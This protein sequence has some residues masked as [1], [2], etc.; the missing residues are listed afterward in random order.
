MKNRM[1]R[2]SRKKW[3][4]HKVIT[5]STKRRHANVRD[6]ITNYNF[7]SRDIVRNR[8]FGERKIAEIRDHEGTLS[9]VSLTWVRLLE[10]A[11][12]NGETKKIDSSGQSE[13][14]F[15]H[16][17]RQSMNNIHLNAHS[18]SAKY[19]HILDIWILDW[20]VCH[21]NFFSSSNCTRQ[22]LI[23]TLIKESKNQN[24]KSYKTFCK[25]IK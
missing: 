7:D 3:N 23:F 20:P 6:G 22:I 25:Q 8:L 21:F 13:Y 19:C 17:S 9:E 14:N 4:A 10:S 12:Q 1:L 5:F 24:I 11:P 18:Q 2:K 16:T 15:D